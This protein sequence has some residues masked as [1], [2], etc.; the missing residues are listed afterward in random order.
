M[1]DH[2]IC[3]EDLSVTA[4]RLRF[5]GSIADPMICFGSADGLIRR[6]S[7]GQDYVYSE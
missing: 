7:V 4:D 5:N 1:P 6:Q 3:V 2:T